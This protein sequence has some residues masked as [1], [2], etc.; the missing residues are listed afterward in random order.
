[1]SIYFLRHIKTPYNLNNMISGSKDIAVLPNQKIFSDFPIPN[2]DYI[3]CS[4]LNR[5]RET[6]SLIPAINIKKICYSDSL[7]E[8]D[9][10]ILEG[11]NRQ[12]A[13][14]K[15]P[16]LF[17]NGKIDVNKNIPNGESIED[18]VK[19]IC[20]GILPQIQL[21]EHE[22]ILICS[23][24]QTLKVLYSILYD[25]KINNEYWHSTNF[26]NGQIVLVK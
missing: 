3:F 18:M 20:I 1:M 9:V 6:I 8:R 24:N 7:T 14:S 21:H 19:R 4:P 15:Y 23:H 22:N 12:D 2:F 10:G 13:V 16:E 17:V 11:V 25:I 26:K 5:C